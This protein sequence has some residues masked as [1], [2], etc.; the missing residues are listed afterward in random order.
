MGHSE[1]GAHFGTSKKGKRR[2]AY[3]EF[4]YFFG[5]TINLELRK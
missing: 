4:L 2:L 3:C 5:K 1:I